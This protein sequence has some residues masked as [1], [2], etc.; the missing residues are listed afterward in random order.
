MQM[1]G[2]H[3]DP[4]NQNLLGWDS[5]IYVINSLPRCFCYAA[6]FEMQND[7][8]IPPVKGPGHEV[9]RRAGL[10]GKITLGQERLVMGY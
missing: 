7:W 1:A 6:R 2:S 10:P 8:F 9:G 4:L 3:S 5:G